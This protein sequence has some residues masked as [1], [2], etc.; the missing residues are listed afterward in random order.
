MTVGQ[1]QSLQP[2][3]VHVNRLVV[4]GTLTILCL[5]MAIIYDSKGVRPEYVSLGLLYPV[6]GFRHR[7]LAKC[8]SPA[9]IH[10]SPFITQ[11][12]PAIFIVLR[13]I[14]LRNA[15]SR[16]CTCPGGPLRQAISNGL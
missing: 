4:F 14:Y 16:K 3:G 11:I 12:K 6:S 2:A 9:A 15:D 10:H 13:V 1:V 8:C 7:S 5:R